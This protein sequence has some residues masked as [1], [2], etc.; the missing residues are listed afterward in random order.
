ML[1]LVTAAFMACALVAP[2]AAQDF[3]NR[4]IR[5]IVPFGPGGG[6]DIVGR[7]FGQS[8][9]E[10]L[11]QPVIIENKAGAGGA[12]AVT[13]LKSMAADGYNLVAT[14]STTIFSSPLARPTVSL[15]LPLSS[16]IR[17][18]IVECLLS[19]DI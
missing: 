19:S 15:T 9:Q 10:K 1:R 3:P 5:I 16:S 13:T 12:V 17:P 6:G 7:I 18:G 4:P 14:T 8:L 2:A 11:G